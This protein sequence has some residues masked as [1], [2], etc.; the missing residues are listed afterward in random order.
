MADDNIRAALAYHEADP[1]GKIAIVPTKPV[2]NQHDLALAYSPGVAH[3]CLAIE[4]DPANASKYTA[5]ANLVGVITNGTAVLGLGNIG[6][7][8]SKPVMEGK[9]VLFKKFAG[10]DCFDIEVATEDADTFVNAVACLEPTFGGI[11]LED[12]KAPE[13]FEIERRLKEKMKIPVFHDDQHGTAI[14]VASGIINGLKIVGKDLADVKLVA[15]GA[16]A[17]A[18]ACLNLLVGLGLKRENTFVCDIEGVVYAGRKE[19]MDPY[20]APFARETD[21]RTLAEVMPDADVFLGLSAAGVVKPEMVAAMAAKPLIFALANPNP[22]IMPED[23]HAVRD[24]AVMA[25]GRTD[26]PNQINNVLCF[27]FIFRGA[28][29]VGATQVNEEMKKAAVLAL[30]SIAENEAS[31]IVLAAYQS[32]SLVFGPEYI[33][34]KPF[35]PRLI[36]EIAPAVARAAME[37]GVATRPIEDFDAYRDKLSSFVYQSGFVMKPIFDQARHAHS[38]RPRRLVFAEGA[39]PYVLQAAQQVISEQIAEPILIGNPEDI[40]HWIKHLGLRMR[41]GKDV[42]VFDQANDPRIPALTDE[43]LKLVERRGVPPSHARRVINAGATVVAGLLLR[44]GDADAMICGAVGRY[45]AHLRHV[46]Q[47]IGQRPVVNA[48]ASLSGLILPSGP[49]FMADTHVNHEPDAETLAEITL[50]AAEEVRRFGITPKIALLSHSNF[51]TRDDKSSQ[52]MRRVLK[53]LNEFDPTMEVE[54]EMHA[55]AAIST[56]IRE[57]NFPNS[58][59]Q[60]SANLLIMPTLDAAHIAFTL[61]RSVTKSVAIGPMLLGTARPAHIVTTSATVRSMLNMSAL[62]IVDSVRDEQNATIA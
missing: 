59:L 54:G 3:A 45:L 52:K 56:F 40:M 18:L 38:E 47:V 43:Y 42:Q 16:G 20:K 36:T 1:P 17:A 9:S 48:L 53:L 23:V 6:P 57:D 8:A 4:E 12:I 19:L 29:D 34:P 37:T 15:S 49:L 22:E 11:N 27:P 5:R 33:L 61:L 2:A 39:H 35:D 21:K 32:E 60:G 50:M 51:G 13:C 26:Y 55:D 28:L 44:R 14:V 24:D 41:I 58:R 30:A 7:L 62:A 46:Q 10:I 25:S 31:D